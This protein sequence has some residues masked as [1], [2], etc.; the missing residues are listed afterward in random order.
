MENS[1][2]EKCW[3]SENRAELSQYLDKYNNYHC[4]EIDFIIESGAH[5][6]CDAACGFGAYTLA[7]ASNGF[8]VKSFDISQEAVA[9]SKLGLMKYGYDIDFKVADIRNTGYNTGEFDGVFAHSVL[10]H[11][12][13]SDARIA[14]Q[15]LCRIVRPDGLILL[16]F[17][18]PEDDDYEIE[19]TILEDGSILYTG[20]T[21]RAGMIF[22]PYDAMMIHKIVEGKEIVFE[23][24]NGKNKQ[25]VIL[26]NQL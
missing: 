15:E 9:I 19:H 7:L 2:W 6:V 24:V 26:K 25:I 4:E 8:T 13:Y 12:T 14:L 17:D 20:D 11:M 16:S 10:D 22:H 18:T 5:Y 21:D 23:S 1:F 3:K